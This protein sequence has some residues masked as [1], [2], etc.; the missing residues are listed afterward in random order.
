V[1]RPLADGVTS[2]TDLVE[3]LGISKGYASKLKKQ[4]ENL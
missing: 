4:V 1:K 2:V 3:E